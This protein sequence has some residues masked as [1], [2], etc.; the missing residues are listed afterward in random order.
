MHAGVIHDVLAVGDFRKFLGDFPRAPQKQAIGHLHNVRLVNG[1]DLLA[2]IF[3]RVFESELRDA[4]RRLL[5]H[6]LQAFHHPGHD[7]VF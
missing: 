5:R 3:A 1:M 2:L 6:D 7:F 4:R